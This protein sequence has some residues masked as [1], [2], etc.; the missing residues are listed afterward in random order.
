[1]TRLKNHTVT[2]LKTLSQTFFFSHPIFGLLLLMLLSVFD[3]QLFLFSLIS[4]MLGYLSTVITKTPFVLKEWGLITINSFFFG[5]AMK[6]FFLSDPLFYF[7]LLAGAVLIP[8]VCKASVEILQHWKISP[9]VLPYILTTWMLCLITP[10]HEAH[11][12][13]AQPTDPRITSWIS[14]L[15]MNFGSDSTLLVAILKISLSAF[16]GLGRVF[17]LPN[18]FFGLSLFLLVSLFR[19]KLS[20]FFL[21]GLLVGSLTSHLL[22]GGSLDWENGSLNF[23]SGLIGLGLA[24]YE[25]RFQPTKILGFCSLSS[26]ISIA[27]SHLFRSSELPLLTLPYVLTLWIALLSQI[28]KLNFSWRSKNSLDRNEP[29]MRHPQTSGEPLFIRSNPSQLP[30]QISL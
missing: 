22:T 18:P 19:P 8:V 3:F 26:F 1:M 28:P 25:E 9:F 10:S 13:V 11:S 29:S 23:C 30:E 21:G 2:F 6:T 20:L 7:Y 24:S 4:A 27:L 5:S 16:E 14:E 17:F 15:M 12:F